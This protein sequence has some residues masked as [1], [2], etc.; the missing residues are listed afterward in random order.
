MDFPF[1]NS[2]RDVL[3]GYDISWKGFINIF[4]LNDVNLQ[5]LQTK[6]SAQF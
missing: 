3:I 5:N 2:K 4:E 1:L 6:I